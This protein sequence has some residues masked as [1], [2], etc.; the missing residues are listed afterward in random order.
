[1]ESISPATIKLFRTP[2]LPLLYKRGLIFLGFKAFDINGV[3][4]EPA[5]LI[6]ILARDVIREGM[7]KSLNINELTRVRLIRGC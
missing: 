3:E 1:M 2:K 5:L 7:N 4:F 6:D